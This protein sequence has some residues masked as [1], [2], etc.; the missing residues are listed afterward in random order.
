[1]GGHSDETDFIRVNTVAAGIAQLLNSMPVSSQFR[2]VVVKHLL[3]IAKRHG[4][5]DDMRRFLTFYC[6]YFDSVKKRQ[7]ETGPIE[8]TTSQEETTAEMAT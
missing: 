1:M 3:K 6:N 2:R 5:L 8:S 4:C 7:V